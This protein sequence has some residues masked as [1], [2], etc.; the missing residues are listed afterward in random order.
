MGCDES[1]GLT[2]VKILADEMGIKF[3]KS[4]MFIL[5]YAKK[6]VRD[7]KKTAVC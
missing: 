6:T 7:F 1:N 5:K 4:C 2:L 3:G